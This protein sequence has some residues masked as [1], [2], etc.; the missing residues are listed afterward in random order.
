MAA[1][2]IEEVQVRDL[3]LPY[4]AVVRGVKNCGGLGKETVVLVNGAQETLQVLDVGGLGVS[5]DGI[6]I[7]LEGGDAG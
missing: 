7:G 2:V 6:H 1:E 3:G 5:Q 4:R